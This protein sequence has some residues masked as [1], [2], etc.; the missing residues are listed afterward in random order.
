MLCLVRFVVPDLVYLDHFRGFGRSRSVQFLKAPRF[1]IC[2]YTVILTEL[3]IMVKEKDAIVLSHS[4]KNSAEYLDAKSGKA[5]LARLATFLPDDEVETNDTGML[6][7]LKRNGQ[8]A[9]MMDELDIEQI[10][11]IKPTILTEAGFAS[12]PR[13][14]LGKLRNFAL[15][16]S[17]SRVAQ[18]SESPDLHVIQAI[19]LL[20]ETDK[21]ANILFG[22]VREWYG[23][24]FPEL[25]NL[26]DGMG[27]YCRVV[28]VGRR[29]NLTLET[30]IDAGFP[31]SK[32]EML[33]LVAKTSRGGDI[34][35][36][37]LSH[38][39]SV[40]GQVLGLYDAH[41]S[42][43]EHI[44]VQMKA[45]APNLTMITGAG[46]G[47]RLLARAG[48]LERLSTMAASTIQVLG[49]EKALFRSIKTGSRP[50][51]HGLIFQHAMVHR[52]P[53]WQRGKIARAIASKA[54]IAARMDVHEPVLNET[55]FEKL[56]VRVDEIGEKYAE[57]PVKPF[58]PPAPRRKREPKKRQSG[59]RR[60]KRKKRKRR[61][62]KK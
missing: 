40:A 4:F 1:T 20:D 52:A 35:D 42:I 46:V 62:G 23:L 37:N 34:S 28:K 29:E 60:L 9:R 10:Q 2:M 49:A 43:D 27:G 56:N 30:F 18:I 36:E 41:R 16:L 53:R 57:A 47:A 61:F 13:D 8:D 45:I 32:A 7:W 51:K 5:R 24:H 31:E 12:N 44:T 38:I 15:E 54:V 25:E 17:S 50:P 59:G 58:V 33:S 19:S 48:S 55:L 11:D 26:V 22:R 3:G 21:V 6:V 14:A 39:Q